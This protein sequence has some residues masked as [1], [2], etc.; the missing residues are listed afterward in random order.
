MTEG[1]LMN[2]QG[3]E[4]WPHH[5]AATETL[6]TRT[7]STPARAVRPVVGKNGLAVAA[8]GLGAIGLIT[9]IVLI[10]GLLGVIGLA[11]GI[12]ALKTARRTG[13]GRAMSIAGVVTSFIAIVVS[14]L[15]GIFLVW[16]AHTTQSCY[17]F[18]HFR[19]YEK[20]VSQRF[21]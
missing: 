17:K 20:C 18:N 8:A 13:V 11:L 19:P 3:M 21:K 12:A 10:G 7:M 4:T 6:S 15:A 1:R 9:S 5:P 16:Y 14:V 2:A